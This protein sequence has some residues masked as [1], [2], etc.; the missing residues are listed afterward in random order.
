MTPLSCKRHDA[1]DSTRGCHDA[2]ASVNVSASSV[3]NCCVHCCMHCWP[4]YCRHH[5]HDDSSTCM[6]YVPAAPQ[7]EA[8]PAPVTQSIMYSRTKSPH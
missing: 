8:A 6:Q 7:S 3:Q 5:A 2:H 4:A 1:L